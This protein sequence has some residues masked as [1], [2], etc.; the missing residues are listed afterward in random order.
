MRD[1]CSLKAA[2]RRPRWG[3]E[4]LD[5]P[6]AQPM[7]TSGRGKSAG[8]HWL[9]LVSAKVKGAGLVNRDWQLAVPRLVEARMAWFDYAA[10][11]ER[12]RQP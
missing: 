11:G 10:M 1:F 12:P 2:L 8:E 6:A 7:A 5:R 3:V 4:S 9:A